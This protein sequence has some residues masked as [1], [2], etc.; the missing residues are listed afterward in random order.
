MALNVLEESSVGIIMTSGNPDASVDN[1]LAGVDFRYLNTRLGDDRSIEATAWYQ[2]TDTEGLSG[3]DSGYGFSFEVPNSEGWNGEIGYKALEENYFPALG[4]ASRTDFAATSAEFGYTWRPRDSWIRS[5]ET[6]IE[7]RVRRADRRQRAQPGD[8]A[9]ALRGPEPVR[10][11]PDA[12]A[13]PDRRGVRWSHSRF[14][15][16]S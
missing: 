6:E 14:R 13:H 9:Q 1:T 2:Q 8:R 3:D 11:Q 16:A 12:R 15:K 10:G 5:I 7:R 4:F